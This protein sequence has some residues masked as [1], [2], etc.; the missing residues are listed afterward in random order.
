MQFTAFGV[1][2][3]NRAKTVICCQETKRTKTH[4][5]TSNHTIMQKGATSTTTGSW[6]QFLV[7]NLETYVHLN[8]SVI[9]P[10]CICIECVKRMNAEKLQYECV[11][12]FLQNGWLTTKNT[13]IDDVCEWWASRFFLT[14]SHIIRNTEQGCKIGMPT[15]L[16]ESVLLFY[17]N[18]KNLILI[19]VVWFWFSGQ[20]KYQQRLLDKVRIL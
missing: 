5:P 20:L 11:L 8:E 3:L 13:T 16:N 17:Y 9:R 4:L 1:V 18:L 15:S 7:G 6:F 19:R 12:Q 10:F 14:I 2:T